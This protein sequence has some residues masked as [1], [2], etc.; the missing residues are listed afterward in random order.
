M[1]LR[2]HTL[3]PVFDRVK[4]NRLDRRLRRAIGLPD[5]PLILLLVSQVA[6][7]NY[8]RG[9]DPPPILAPVIDQQAV[10]RVTAAFL[11][12]RVGTISTL[13]R[14]IWGIG[15]R[16]YVARLQPDLGEEPTSA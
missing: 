8:P 1:L 6:K 2:C 14:A 4:R 15:P 16:A 5:N 9:A 7:A 13:Y 12:R 3:V 11:D 10:A